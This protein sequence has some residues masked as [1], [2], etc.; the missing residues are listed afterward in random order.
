MYLNPIGRR[1]AVMGNSAATL[2]AAAAEPETET[3]RTA[4]VG[5]SWLRIRVVVHH[6][7]IPRKIPTFCSAFDRGS[8]QSVEQ[9]RGFSTN[10]AGERRL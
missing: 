4:Q 8:A 3:G 1:Y 7:K 9:I 6:G 2:A 10:F 5:R